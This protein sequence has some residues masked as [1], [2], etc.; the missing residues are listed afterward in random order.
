MLSNGEFVV[1]ARATQQFE[2]LL[3]A[4]NGINGGSS[5][6]DNSTNI[7]ITNNGSGAGAGFL[8]T[9]LLPN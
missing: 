2:P 8:P 4:I 3:E 9:F 5:S 7:N 6:V 1:N